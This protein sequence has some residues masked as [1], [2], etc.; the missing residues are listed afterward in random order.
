MTNVS[1]SL[2]VKESKS[3]SLLNYILSTSIGFYALSIILVVS[4]TILN[5]KK[6]AILDYLKKI[7]KMH[8]KKY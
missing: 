1:V 2:H 3:F 5:R 6:R 4:I 8:I 7:K